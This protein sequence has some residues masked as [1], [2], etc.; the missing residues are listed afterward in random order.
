[1]KNQSGVSMVEVLIALV[2]FAIGVGGMAGLQLRSISMSVDATQRAVVLAKSQE[3]ADRM[4]S[5]SAALVNYI[6]SSP[7]NNNDGSYCAAAPADNCADSQSG[8]ATT[9]TAAQMATF[10]L[11]DVFCAS[12]TGLNQSVIE[13]NADITCTSAACNGAQDTVTITTSWVSKTADSNEN[14]I[15]TSSAATSDQLTLSFIP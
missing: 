5:N 3:L 11:W 15:R 6:N 13:W 2:V 9:C 12:Q 7:Y 4:R 14:L 10:D 8:A 1:M